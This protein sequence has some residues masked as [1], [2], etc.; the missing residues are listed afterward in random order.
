MNKN[1]NIFVGNT[2]E[3]K[4]GLSLINELLKL[5]TKTEGTLRIKLNRILPVADQKQKNRLVES[6]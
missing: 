2:S 1:V 4:W 3:K 6:W 5:S